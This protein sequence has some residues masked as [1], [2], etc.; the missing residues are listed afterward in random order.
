MF[1]SSKRAVKYKNKCHV[2]ELGYSC[3]GIVSSFVAELRGIGVAHVVERRRDAL[4][5]GADNSPT[6]SNCCYLFI[7]RSLLTLHNNNGDITVTY[8]QTVRTRSIT[9]SAQRTISLHFQ[10]VGEF[11]GWNSNTN[12]HLMGRL[13][14][15]VHYWSPR[16]LIAFWYS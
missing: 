3:N 11:G 5:W 7:K 13:R 14:L 8:T 10:S 2:Y 16:F 1:V 12:E 6:D 4:A 15:R 9:E